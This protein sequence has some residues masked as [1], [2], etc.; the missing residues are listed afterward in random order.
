MG[1]TK[2]RAGSLLAAVLLL[3]SARAEIVILK[4]GTFIEGSIKLTT[5]TNIRMDTRFGMRTF[6]VADIDRIV[7]SINDS[8][9]ASQKTFADLPAATRAILNAQAE[10]DLGQYEKAL[11]RIEPFKDKSENKAVR[12]GMDWLTIDIQERLGR[13]DEAKKMLKDK[14][15]S[16]T[17]AEKTRAKAHL[18]IFEVNPQYDLRY[19]GEKHARNFLFEEDLRNKA[20][21]PGALR[22]A[23]I[24]RAAL[25]EYCEQLL[26]ENKQG[27]LA[28]A[29]KLDSKTTLEAI[30][31]APGSG[32]LSL[33]LPYNEQLNKA[34]AALMKS[35]AVL[36][37]YSSAF[38]LDLARTEIDHLF[39][40]FFTLLG[41]AVRFSPE[42]F[43]PPSDRG[44]GNLTA[45]G[46]RQWQQRCDQFLDAM[47]PVSRLLDY[48]DARTELYPEALRDF[49]KLIVE[50]NARIKE[51]IRAVK[52]A[53]DR[54]RV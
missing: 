30:K 44:S 51:N 2:L 18:D 27:V 28:F 41:E 6:K 29:E 43:I 12:M 7:E 17:A 24:M 40:V 8:S 34:E 5:K 49:R 13:W 15:E 42:G 45:D 52:Q 37:D 11:S 3:S 50:V 47:K 31:K 54:T 10:Y 38:E 9:S 14:L 23:K 16:G 20:K 33:H 1:R 36:G 32:D 46:R 21:E 26:V 22:D 35:Q 25:E 48:L 53:R 19:V 39:D 4:D